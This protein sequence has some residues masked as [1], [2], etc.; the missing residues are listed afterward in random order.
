MPL[1][2]L[3]A[4]SGLYWLHGVGPDGP[5]VLLGQYDARLQLVTVID[6]GCTAHRLDG[7]RLHKWRVY[8]I[9]PVVR[10]EP[11]QETPHE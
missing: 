3:P 10:P 4:H 2:P 5:V 9:M 1:D 7:D 8:R 11:A 6:D